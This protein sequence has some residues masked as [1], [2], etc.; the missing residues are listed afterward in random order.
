MIVCI[1]GTIGK[2]AINERDVSCNQQINAITVYK[3]ISNYYIFYA[4]D[5][6]FLQNNI[7]KSA[8]GSATPI[9]NKLKLL[10]IPLPLPP[11]AE[12]KRIVEKVDQLFLL[13]DELERL[14][15]SRNSKRKELHNS[16]LTQ[17]LEADSVSSF[18]TS[19]QFLTTHFHELYSVKENVKEL[20]KAVLQLAVM[21]KLVPQ[22]K[23][24]QPARELLKEIQAE[25]ERLVKEGKIRK[26]DALPPIK[27]E[28][29]PFVLPEGWEWV[30]FFNVCF[31]KSELVDSK[32]Y[33]NYF[34]IA[35][36]S[37]EKGTG[38]LLEDRTVEEAKVVG[39]NNKFYKGQIL[40]SKI[41][42]SLSKAIIASYDGLCS[43]DM[44]PI[45]SMIDTD[46]N[47]KLILS[48]LFLNQVRIA[49]NRVKMP[50]INLESLGLFILPLPPLAE[51][52]RIVEKVDELLAL[53]DRLEEEIE[54]AELKR[55]EILE[56]MVRV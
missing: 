17:C 14:Q 16:V 13:C 22:D 24:D 8:G 10:N 46:Y 12:Q 9:I 31:V 50:K 21:G 39:P 35:P 40:Y 15:Q 34:Q 19:F 27:D 53:C 41:R 51:Q 44:Y 2:I 29:K 55:G 45:W 4:I 48:E 18:Q 7:L 37:I 52:K 49:E 43:A 26:M 30:R 36:D 38:R 56:G 42:P 32:E 5:S 20:R 25:K 28:E 1:G 6:P 33:I 47:L 54:K 3:F 11:L 23:N